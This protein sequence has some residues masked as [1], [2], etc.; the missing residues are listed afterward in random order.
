MSRS[1]AA[2]DAVEVHQNVRRFGGQLAVGLVGRQVTHELH[3]DPCV[4][5]P[6]E[7][8]Q[9]QGCFFTPDLTREV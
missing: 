7:L 6:I 2:S 8:T 4:G 5:L 1:E 3:R 9:I